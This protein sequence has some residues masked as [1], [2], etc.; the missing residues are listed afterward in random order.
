MNK[1]IL[2]NVLCIKLMLNISQ[3]LYIH[4][5]RYVYDPDLFYVIDKQALTDVIPYFAF[6]IFVS[7]LVII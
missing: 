7:I 3:I 2:Y 4:N 5:H 1:E 6:A